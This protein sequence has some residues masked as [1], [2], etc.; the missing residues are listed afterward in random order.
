MT[1]VEKSIRKRFTYGG[2]KK[3]GIKKNVNGMREERK[4]LVIT[5]VEIERARCFV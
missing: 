3:N 5:Y 1:V 2:G 4:T